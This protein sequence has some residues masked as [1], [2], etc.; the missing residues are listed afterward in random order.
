MPDSG[1]ELVG[2]DVRDGVA[3]ARI[4][5]GKANALSFDVLAGLDRCLTLA[6]ED[7]AVGALVINGTPGFGEWLFD[8][9]NTHL[10][11]ALESTGMAKSFI[12][13]DVTILGVPEEANMAA[14]GAQRYAQT[15][16]AE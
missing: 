14:L 15:L 12:A 1:T 8:P 11:K 4:D 2:Y 7:A 9:K 3:W 5:N 16:R 6:E 13:Q 10:L